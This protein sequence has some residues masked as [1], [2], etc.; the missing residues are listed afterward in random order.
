MGEEVAFNGITR[1]VLKNRKRLAGFNEIA[2]LQIRT[3][4]GGKSEEHRLTAVL[5]TGDKIEIYTTYTAHEIM[6][7]ADDAADILGVRVVRKE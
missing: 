7:L 3:I 4:R 5:Q 2:H 1:T 6:A